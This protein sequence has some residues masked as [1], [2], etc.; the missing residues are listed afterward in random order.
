MLISYAI[1]FC[2]G[3]IP[4]Q[5]WLMPKDPFSVGEV[6]SCA[7]PPHA[8]VVM[9]HPRYACM[10]FADES[11]SALKQQSLA[12]MLDLHCCG[13]IP[14]LSLDTVR[15]RADTCTVCYRIVDLRRH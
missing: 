10:I 11:L 13:Q 5:L 4:F 9:M 6:R 15:F 1:V 8:D 12:Y 3:L 7:S 2:G 14:L